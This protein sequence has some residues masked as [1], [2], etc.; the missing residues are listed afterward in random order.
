MA[1]IYSMQKRLT[2]RVATRRGGSFEAAE[3][4]LALYD[5][6]P[7]DSALGTSIIASGVIDLP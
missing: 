7:Q 3:F 4:S 6:T 1:P 5:H 2:H